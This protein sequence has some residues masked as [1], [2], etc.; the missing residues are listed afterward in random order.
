MSR[1]YD[2][3]LTAYLK[4]NETT[5]SA[6]IF[7]KWSGI[8]T[9]AAT[10]RRKVYFNFGRI[11]IYPNLFV[12]LVAEPGVARKTQA[13]TFAEDIL[14]GIFGVSMAADAMT[15]QAL[16]EDIELA[17]DTTIM[18]D[19][20]ELR[21]SSLTIFSGE[22]ESFLG[23]KKENS[24]MIV[25]LTDL[26]D[27]KARP[28]RYRTKNSGSNIIPLPFLN[29]LAAT[30]PESLANCLPSIAI[31][32]GL[33]SR[34]IFVY[35]NDKKQKVP[36]PEFTEG[37]ANMQ[38]ELL[39]DLSVIARTAGGYDFSTEG[40]EWWINFYNSYE[41]RDSTR[42]CKDPAFI[43]WYSR[44]P[45]LI[46]KLSTIFAAAKRQGF[47]VFPEDFE[48]AKASL[49]EVEVLMGKA[50]SAVGRS[51]LTADVDMLR[52]ILER[53]K[54]ISEKQLRRMVWR[55]IDDKKFSSVIDT[56]VK[57]GDAERRF[58]GPDNKRGIWY[59]WNKQSGGW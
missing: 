12:I 15:P 31:G 51:D 36:I 50:F 18:P 14:I 55:D 35:A 38:E 11:K 20:S 23:Q 24:K 54:L 58:I 39:K 32:G 3:W 13:I 48:D 53:S 42:L 7:H 26:Y 2:N 17:A 9:I 16:L 4:Y 22:F 6:T 52:K 45:V 40:K 1:I 27:C 59:Y 33:T 30:T 8:S 21:H 5:E 57:G 47:E 25:T 46:L 49:E 43:G 44:K 34:M 37:C 19:G 10:L 41:D 28:F 29:M 56:I